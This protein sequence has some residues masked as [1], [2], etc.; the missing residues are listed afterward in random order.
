MYFKALS[1]KKFSAHLW[2][3]FASVKMR[4]FKNRDCSYGD[5][6][7]SPCVV[8]ENKIFLVEERRLRETMEVQEIRV[9]E[10]GRRRDRDSL[11]TNENGEKHRRKPSSAL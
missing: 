11:I 5:Q 6:K 2:Q 4:D 9:F 8:Q 10:K 1:Y 3:V 7:N